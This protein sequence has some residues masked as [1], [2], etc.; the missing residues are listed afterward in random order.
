MLRRGLGSF[1][2][3]T[4]GDKCNNLMH[5]YSHNNFGYS[6][7]FRWPFRASFQWQFLQTVK[8]ILTADKFS[9][10]GML[11]IQIGSGF[12]GQVE[13][14]S[15]KS[16]LNSAVATDTGV[17][18]AH[19]FL[20]LCLPW[21]EPLGC[22]VLRRLSCRVRRGTACS[23]MIHPLHPY[24][25]GHLI[26]SVSRPETRSQSWGIEGND[27]DI[28]HESWHQPMEQ[29]TIILATSCEH[30]KIITCFRGLNR[31]PNLSGQKIAKIQ[32]KI[33]LFAKE[34]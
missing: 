11:L 23:S 14:R 4:I 5:G 16:E 22:H 26:G 2:A 17:G 1:I 31:R 3:A 6:D 28:Y 21:Q 30:Q 34:L 19:W 7:R 27:T 32:H 24:Q 29:A 13:L 9:K 12:E 33:Y 20:A 15:S 18:L 10:H 8:D 25:S